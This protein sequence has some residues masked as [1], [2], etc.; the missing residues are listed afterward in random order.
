MRASQ[1]FIGTLPFAAPPVICG[2]IS[3]ARIPAIPILFLT[4]LY[5]YHVSSKTRSQRERESGEM[6]HDLVSF[7]LLTPSISRAPLIRLPI[8]ASD[9]LVYTST[10]NELGSLPKSLAKR[11]IR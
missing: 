10:I 6:G 7:F 3:C 4:M 11:L 9:Y 5:L 2:V 1:T 8:L